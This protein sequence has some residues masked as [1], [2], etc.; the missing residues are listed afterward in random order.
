MWFHHVRNTE[1]PV[2]TGQTPASLLLKSRRLGWFGRVCR[3]GPEWLPKS[4][5][6][7]IPEKGKRR[8]GR[9]RTRWKD[10]IRRDAE[11]DGV[12]QDPEVVATDRTQGRDVLALLL[13]SSCPDDDDDD[14]DAYR[15][16]QAEVSWTPYAPAGITS[17]QNRPIL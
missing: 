16:L 14:D 9:C 1:V 5:L 11:Y 2:R 4:L 6:S 7:W 8:R 10:T 15:T 13:M 12:E 17:T 3:I